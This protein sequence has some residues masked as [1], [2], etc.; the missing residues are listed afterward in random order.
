MRKEFDYVESTLGFTL[1]DPRVVL[2]NNDDSIGIRRPT[3]HSPPID[4]LSIKIP[5]KNIV[6]IQYYAVK[7][8]KKKTNKLL[9]GA[10]G[11][12]VLGGLMFTP[13]GPAI[14]GAKLM[15]VGL[16][17]SKFAGT[18]AVGGAING[19]I[20]GNYVDV[21]KNIAGKAKCEDIFMISYIKE[22]E[23]DKL[24]VIVFEHGKKNLSDATA[25]FDKLIEQTQK[26]PKSDMVVTFNKKLEP[27]IENA[28]SFRSVDSNG[29]ASISITS[30]ADHVGE[31]MSIL[32]K[33]NGR[34]EGVNSD[35]GGREVVK[36]RITQI[37]EIKNFV[38]AL[39]ELFGGSLSV[40]AEG[41]FMMEL[42]KVASQATYDEI[43][44]LLLGN[45]S[46]ES[47]L[48][49]EIVESA[50]VFHG[51]LQ[52]E[53]CGSFEADITLD[54]GRS[55][56]ANRKYTFY[57]NKD[58][59]IKVKIDGTVSSS[60]RRVILNDWVQTYINAEFYI[61]DG[62]SIMGEGKITKIIS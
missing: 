50:N 62:N 51:D 48:E 33:H 12:V 25:F 19:V 60:G 58:E 10:V 42:G 34:V 53:R 11:A 57:I 30:H 43:D 36:A 54:S 3:T 5:M 46:D 47:S 49:A 40:S 6:D 56:V 29:V 31:I 26:T 22:S 17:A 23:P 13:L 14:A 4:N 41:W 52:L 15:S 35:K 20:I 21:V 1:E 55:F 45:S 8:E 32:N 9:F 39:S 24:N 44:A 61:Y 28:I 18:F 27:V 16:A 59:A 7:K 38:S 37:A 2:I